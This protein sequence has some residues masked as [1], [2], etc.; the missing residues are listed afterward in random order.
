MQ[1]D[2]PAARKAIGHLG[3]RMSMDVERTAAGIHRLVNENMANAARVHAAERGVDFRAYTLVATGGAGPVH[4]C[5][6][7]E[8]LGLRS[9]IIPP[10]AGVGSAFGLMLAPI[11]FD[12]SR[13]YVS[14]LEEL[15][16]D[17]LNELFNEMEFAGQEVVASAG[18]QEK[19]V[20]VIRTSDMRYV[21][22]GHEIRVPIPSGKLNDASVGEIQSA[23]DAVYEKL[24]G[25]IC[26]GVPVQSVHWRVT[27]S[28]PEPMMG[29]VK[30]GNGKG[31]EEADKGTRLAVF[32]PDEGAVET[33][34]LNR[35]GLAPG[36]ASQGPLIVEEIESTTVVSPGWSVHVDQSGNLV[37]ERKEDANAGKN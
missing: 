9:V 27:V 35:Y 8:R 12:F 5:G 20:R 31:G 30:V 23:F 28:G 2:P 7:A 19:D 10:A 21:G 22:Q 24:Y 34:V 25:R 15:E 33:A 13:S 32:N 29:E 16:F 1:L 4:A 17:R 14:R 26:E 18:V 3:E 6:V 11:S 37:L 36:F